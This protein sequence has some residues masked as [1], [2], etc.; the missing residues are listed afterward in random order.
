M[1]RLKVILES[2]PQLNEWPSPPGE[3][4]RDAD[5]I[6]LKGSGAGLEPIPAYASSIL[7]I[8]AG[9]ISRDCVG[10]RC[11]GVALLARQ[12]DHMDRRCFRAVEV[13][14]QQHGSPESAVLGAVHLK[15]SG[16]VPKGIRLVKP[17]LRRRGFLPDP[18]YHGR[19]R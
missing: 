5:Q 4:G 19:T 12:Q 14:S 8:A 1:F 16:G 13:L 2:V 18:S 10:R 15:P 17:D 9:D 7:E 3:G 6:D 11:H